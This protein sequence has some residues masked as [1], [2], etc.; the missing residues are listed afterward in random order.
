[1]TRDL[2]HCFA[3]VC[4]RRAIYSLAAVL[5]APPLFVAIALY[6]GATLTMDIVVT[7]WRELA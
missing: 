6:M 4:G 2:C 5:L 7:G 1:M 3:C